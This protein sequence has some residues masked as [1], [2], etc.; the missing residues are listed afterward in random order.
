MKEESN[1]RELSAAGATL[2]QG[3]EC[4][5]LYGWDELITLG[6]KLIAIW[7]LITFAVL[8]LCF[9]RQNEPGFFFLV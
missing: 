1:S 3:E 4:T 7:G 8:L 6:G 9:E 2:L 5:R